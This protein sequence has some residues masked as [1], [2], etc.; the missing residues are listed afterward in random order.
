[1]A[2]LSLPGHSWSLSET[3]SVPSVVYGYTQT[4]VAVMPSPW[5]STADKYVLA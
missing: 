5:T 3:V 1:M 2:K 4:T